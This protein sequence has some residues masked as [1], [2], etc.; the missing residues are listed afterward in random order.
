MLPARRPGPLVL[1]VLLAAL[2]AAPALGAPRIVPGHRIGP[3]AIGAE[4]ALV[5]AAIGPG[6][7]VQRTPSA[8]APR[9]RNLDRV[10]VAYPA[11]RIVAT[12]PTDEASAIA[13]RVTTRSPRYRTRGGIG[14]GSTRAAVRAAHPRAACSSSSCRIGARAPDAV[15]TRL[16]L[17]GGRVA[18]VDL[19]RL[20]PR[21]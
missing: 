4:R 2:A 18:R 9:N 17:V 7:V 19:V 16:V 5:E 14:V 20:P 11:W 21:P 13:R 1:A 10:R 15:V 8:H 3:V 12:F 6:V